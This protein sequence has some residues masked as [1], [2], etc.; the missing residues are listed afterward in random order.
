MNTLLIMDDALR[1]PHLSCYGYPKPTSPNI[2]RLAAEG[3]RFANCVAV[4]SHTFPPIVS[5]V[6]GEFT[7]THGLMTERDYAGWKHGG[8]WEGHRTPLHVL[9]EH[10]YQVD[11]EFA[12][13]WSPLG[14]TRDQDDVLAYLEKNLERRWFYF[15]QPYPTHLPYNPPQEYYEMFVDK[16]FQPGPET[17]ERMEIVKTRMICHPPNVTAALE[18]GQEDSIPDPGGTVHA[19]SSAVVDLKPEDAPGIRALYDGEIRVLDDYVGRVVEMLEGQGKL[20]DTLII[21]ISDHGE[22]LMERG[23]VG[24]TSCNLMGTLYDE[25]LHVPLI[26]RCPKKLP[27]GVVIENQVSHVDLMP[28]IFE[29]LGL[30]FDF[31]ADGSS[32]MPLIQGKTNR[33][34]EETYAE[35]PPA[36]WQALRADKRRIYCVRTLDWKLI[37][38]V[39][40]P[41]GP[42]AYELYNLRQDPGERNNLIDR[43]PEKAA[44]LKAKLEAHFKGK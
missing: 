43:E 13:R 30:K 41:G 44:E 19:R 5:M 6:T 35:A 7:A 34:R 20:D 39:E 21:I 9:A 33:F 40:Y 15:A 23:H 31:E 16:D 26:M 22:E 1:A 12:M 8:L 24:H 38:N 14:F 11:G 27:A 37:K 29:L 18:V 42:G 17:L 3:V 36:G 25:C 28:T 10:G 4:C 2:D 32:L